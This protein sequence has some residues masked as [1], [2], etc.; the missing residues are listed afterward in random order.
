MKIFPSLKG[1]ILVCPMVFRIQF[2]D[3][4]FSLFKVQPSVSA[5]YTQVDT[6]GTPSGHPADS[7]STPQG[8]VYSKRLQGV[9]GSIQVV[10][11]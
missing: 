4:T 8:W 9:L 3:P 11:C 6:L 10:N 1:K 2:P 5:V 7:L